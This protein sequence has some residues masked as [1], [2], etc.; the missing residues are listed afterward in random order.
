[1]LLYISIWYHFSTAD[2]EVP[3]NLKNHPFSAP[4]RGRAALTHLGKASSAAAGAGLG[5]RLFLLNIIKIICCGAEFVLCIAVLSWM[6]VFARETRFL[7]ETGFL[8]TLQLS[9]PKR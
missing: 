7:K 9:F 2:I 8:S 6:N 5:H 1:M 3:E 4:K